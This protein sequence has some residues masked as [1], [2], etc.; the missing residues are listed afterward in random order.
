MES[1][2][3][4]DISNHIDSGN[5]YHQRPHYSGWQSASSS[6]T[7][8]PFSPQYQS[9]PVAATSFITKPRPPSHPNLNKY[10]PWIVA[11]STVHSAQAAPHIPSFV[12]ITKLQTTKPLIS[13]T[14]G[15][16]LWPSTSTTTSALTNNTT[17]TS[18]PGTIS[19][20]ASVDLNKVV[21]LTSS[22]NTN[23]S[24]SASSVE[25]PA[26]KFR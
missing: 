10:K 5:H 14:T 12:N 24:L 19:S 26:R 20:A 2:E 7:F 4:E 21:N 23:G 9:P 1:N 3:I 6:T 13:T 25:K 11:G 18:V 15:S 17:I 16:T 8:A 22:A